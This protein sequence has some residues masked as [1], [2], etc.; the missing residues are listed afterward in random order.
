MA[1]LNKKAI[2][3]FF[4]NRLPGN[5][6]FKGWLVSRICLCVQ[7]KKIGII[8]KNKDESQIINFKIMQ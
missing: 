1:T 8:I 5:K 6:I 4:G 2:Y 7:E 3:S